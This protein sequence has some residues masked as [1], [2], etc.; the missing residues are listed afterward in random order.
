MGHGV[1]LALFAEANGTIGT[2]HVKEVLA[3]A[4]CAGSLGIEVALLMPA[5]VPASLLPAWAAPIVRRIPGIAPAQLESAGKELAREGIQV[6]LTSFLKISESQARALRNSGLKLIYMDDL[7]SRGPEY[8][9]LEEIYRSL[10][11]NPRAVEGPVRSVIVSMGGADRTGAT[12]RVIEALAGWNLKV[13]RHIVLGA[14]FE[15][16]SEL[17]A[18]LSSLPGRWEIHRNP[19]SLAHWM[20]EADVGICAGGNTLSE[21]AC[22][23]I[24]AAVLYEDPH[25]QEQGSFF[26]REGFGAC[27][28]PGIRFEPGSL[29]QLLERWDDPVLRRAQADRGRQLVDGRGAQRICQRVWDAVSI[30]STLPA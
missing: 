14:L 11:D 4:E 21:M 13:V 17:R 7:L 28:G 2:G 18:R 1:K 12:F 3:I 24:P 27:L 20:R 15:R 9:P 26:E 22:V 6:A 8:L 10:H 23:G 5:E 25:E 29:I 19:G 30:D 16:E